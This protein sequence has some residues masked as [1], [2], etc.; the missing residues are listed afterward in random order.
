MEESIAIK[1]A[2]GNV[3]VDNFDH[4]VT[5]SVWTHGGHTRVH[6]TQEQAKAVAEALNTAINEAAKVE[7]A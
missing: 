3:F 5:L 7:A 1:H 2:E 6:L 4:E